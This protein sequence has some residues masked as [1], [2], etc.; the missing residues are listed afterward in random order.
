[1]A[2]VHPKARQRRSFQR[3]NT[4]I[5][6][7]LSDPK[8]TARLGDLGGIPCPGTPAAFGKVIADETE[9]WRKVIRAAN[10]KPE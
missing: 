5:N 8:L 7:G 3:L 2:S 6:A 10:I 9:K 4:E 1:L